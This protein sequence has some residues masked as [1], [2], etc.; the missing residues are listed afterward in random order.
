M[1]ADKKAA[2]RLSVKLRTESARIYRHQYLT[3]SRTKPADLIAV[4]V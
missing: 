2:K 3:S 1:K 4:K